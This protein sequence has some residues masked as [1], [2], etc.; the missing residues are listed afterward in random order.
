[1]V[2]RT[3]NGGGGTGGFTLVEMLTT[4]AA[5]TIVLGLAVSLA[6]FVRNRSADAATRRMLGRLEG[7]A[8]QYRRRTGAYPALPAI[9]PDGGV[10]GGR[11]DDQALYRAA[12]ANNR[13]MVQAL[14]GYRDLWD[15]AFGDLP[16]AMQNEATLRDAWGTPVV[17][18]PPRAANVGMSPQDRYFVF[19]AGPDR[20]FVT[21]DDNLYSYEIS[22]VR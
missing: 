20:R 8:E 5:L 10:G 18:V 12:M 16:S 15:E 4:V 3:S 6:R 14:R 13:A 2:R 17:F 21:I 9:V 22:L 11:L 7:V 1:V 19:S